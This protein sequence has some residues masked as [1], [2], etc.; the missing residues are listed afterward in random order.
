Y[1]ARLAQSVHEQT[2]Q[3]D[4]MQLVL[5]E[6]I[7]SAGH[8]INQQEL[9]EQIVEYVLP[10]LTEKFSQDILSCINLIPFL[11]LNMAALEKII[12]NKLYALKKPLHVMFN[13][14]L[15]Y[16]PEIIKFLAQ[17]ALWQ[18]SPHRESLD[19]IL[20]RHLYA[21]VSHAALKHMDNKNNALQRLL[22][23]LNEQGQALKCE[24]V[25]IKETTYI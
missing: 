21:C 8:L 16:A 13:L 14:E 7:H 12:Q 10:E 19:K 1:I 2:R 24:F 4:L 17:E 11:P 6:H 3:I 18:R 23:Q 9:I 15:H 25:T 20:E 22:L 5:N